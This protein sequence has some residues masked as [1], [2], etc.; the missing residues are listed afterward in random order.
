MS[1]HKL[2][3]LQ[4][5]I[6]VK[7]GSLIEEVEIGT[8]IELNASYITDRRDEIQFLQWITRIIQSILN[9]DYDGRQQLGVLEKRLEMMDMIEFEN[10]VQERI[11][12]LSIRMNNSNNSRESDLL[13][14]ET[15]VLEC[16]L[17]RLMDLK[18]GA[19]T[20]AIEVANAQ[21][22]FKRA[23]HLRKQLIKIHD[24]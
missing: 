23:N 3:E 9:R 21:N 12:E 16:I 8:N 17:G 2:I 7:V 18:Y 1:K 22:D 13:K 20:Q 14:N 15:E 11:E 6:E 19:E 24:A 5:L 10:L 4:K